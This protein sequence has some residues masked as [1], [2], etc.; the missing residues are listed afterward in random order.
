MTVEIVEDYQS[1]LDFD[2]E[3][4]KRIRQT[5]EYITSKVFKDLKW[6]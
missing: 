3:P 1:D 2:E 5:I 4:P 6:L